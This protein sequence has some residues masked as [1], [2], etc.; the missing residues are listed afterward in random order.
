M[1]ALV[2]ENLLNKERNLSQRKL[3][4][5][6]GVSLGKVNEKMRELKRNGLV[7]LKNNVT[8]KGKKFKG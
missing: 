8:E 4:L 2:L 3:A 1:N 7:D 5:K 6:L